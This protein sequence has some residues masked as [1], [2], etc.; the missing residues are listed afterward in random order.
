MTDRGRP[1]KKQTDRSLPDVVHAIL[2]CTVTA[3]FFAFILATSAFTKTVV[4]NMENAFWFFLFVFAVSVGAGVSVY[5]ARVAKRNA[6]IRAIKDL[7]EKIRKGQYDVSAEGLTGGFKEAGKSLEQLAEHL[8]KGESA[9]ND[10]INDFSHE[11]KTPIVSIRGFA[12]LL[13]KNE[14]TEEERKE[15]LRLI[16]T[17]SDRLID[18]AAGT[19]LLDRLDND[20]LDVETKLY[21]LSE[22]LRRQILMLQSE[23][24]SKNVE[25]IA[26]F[27]EFFVVGNEEL[28]SQLFLNVI[29]NAVKF[30]YDGGKV[31]IAIAE[32]DRS[33]TVRISDEGQGMNAET[34]KRMFDKYFRGDKSRSTQGNGLGLAT[35]KKIAD[36]T[37]VELKVDSKEGKGTDFYVI[38]KK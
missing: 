11:L 15:Y 36:V 29:G 24:E 2:T 33:T 4:I 38:F 19:L 12:K 6:E 7:A 27:Q 35:V 21:N 14:V 9:N 25:M 32:N 1:E 26:D 13:V 16:I 31:T 30:S 20:R 8:K 18:L 10:F 37:G 5:M 23:W 34:Q 28:M 22:Q 17:E 3:G